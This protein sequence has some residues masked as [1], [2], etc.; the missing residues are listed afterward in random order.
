MKWY[1]VDV[2]VSYRR[3]IQAESQQAAEQELIEDHCDDDLVTC[4]AEAEEITKET[5]R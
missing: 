3:E 4:E 5:D 1:R 2:H